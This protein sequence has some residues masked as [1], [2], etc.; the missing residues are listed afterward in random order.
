MKNLTLIHGEC[1]VEM[2]KIP[3]RSIDMILCDLPYGTT[4]NK[5]DVV[6][7]LDRLW[8]Q[9]CRIIKDNGVIVL[10]AAQPFTS[11]LVCSNPKMFKYDLVWEKTVSSNQLNVKI[12]PLRSHESILVFYSKPP[13]YNEQ[14]TEGEPY[15][16]N[17]AAKYTEG[18]YHKQ[19]PSKKVN[20]GY[21]H[22]R[23]VIRVSNPR[24]KGGH[25]TEKP[26]ELL[27]YLIKTYTNPGDVVLDNCMGCGSTGVACRNLERKFIGIELD[28]KYFTCA[29]KKISI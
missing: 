28:S 27:E 13:T 3:P 18:N 5:W 29:Q 4:N 7:P 1:L 24:I 23:S 15:R 20:T 14:L 9:Y 10:T 26:V 22:A 17:R 16:I 21:R 12:Q 19:K 8:E 6:I 2:S 11:Q 25:P